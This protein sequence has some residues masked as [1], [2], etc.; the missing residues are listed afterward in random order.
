MTNSGMVPSVKVVAYRKAVTITIRS[1][2][3]DKGEAPEH[4]FS[5]LFSPNHSHFLYLLI[6]NTLRF[7]PPLHT[8]LHTSFPPPFSITSHIQLDHNT[9]YL[10]L[11]SR[12]PLV[13][14]ALL[15]IPPSSSPSLSLFPSSSFSLPLFH[16]FSNHSS[17]QRLYHIL[18][19]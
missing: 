13:P 8:L 2:P 18:G 7:S 19:I 14:T 1:V 10:T 3:H 6:R 12:I 9:T 17:A 5:F 15:L 16:L 4:P 11:V